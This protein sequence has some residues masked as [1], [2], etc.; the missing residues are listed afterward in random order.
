MKFSPKGSKIQKD[1]NGLF[2]QF[3]A[4]PQKGKIVVSLIMD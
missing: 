3:L 4:D 1:A 2:I